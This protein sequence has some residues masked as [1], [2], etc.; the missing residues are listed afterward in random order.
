MNFGVFYTKKTQFHFNSFFQAEKTVEKALEET[1]E[2]CLYPPQIW[3]LRWA[4]PPHT[5]LWK[6]CV[7]LHRKLS[8]FLLKTQLVV[9][10]CFRFPPRGLTIL[11]GPLLLS[12]CE[13]SLT[14]HEWMWKW[15]FTPYVVEMH[16]FWPLGYSSLLCELFQSMIESMQC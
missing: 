6:L 2:P 12:V 1:G 11:L 3:G 10:C 8:L 7:S 5:Q 4:P 16:L 13:W 14:A 15:S 9:T